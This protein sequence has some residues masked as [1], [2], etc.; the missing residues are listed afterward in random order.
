MR[1]TTTSSFA[2]SGEAR[3][4]GRDFLFRACSGNCYFRRISRLR[5]PFLQILH[6]APPVYRDLQGEV[7]PRLWRLPPVR[8]LAH[9]FQG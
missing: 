8:A 7:S 9:G 2:G 6:L 1:T 5:A 3:V 4:R